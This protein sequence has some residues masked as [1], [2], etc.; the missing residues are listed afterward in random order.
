DNRSLWFLSEESGY[1]HL[2]LAG[3]G[4]PRALT[5]GNWEVSAPVLA[6]DGA[7]FL[8]VCNLSAPAD[9]EVCEVPVAGGQ[10][11]ELT[12]LDGVDDFV[13]SPDGSRLLLRHSSAYVPPQLAVA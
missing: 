11:R 6:A 10:A 12:D 3:D 5:S 9:Y 13:E 8:F 7:R 2:Y 4:R 1:S